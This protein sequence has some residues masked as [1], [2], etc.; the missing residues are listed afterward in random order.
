[1]V[2]GKAQSPLGLWIAI[3]PKIR[4]LPSRQPG[5]SMRADHAGHVLDRALDMG[6]R[7]FARFPRVLGGVQGDD[8]IEPVRFALP[9]FKAL[10]AMNNFR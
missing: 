4:N 1:M 10:P 2:D 9:E 3:N 5:I 6:A 8:A 7:R